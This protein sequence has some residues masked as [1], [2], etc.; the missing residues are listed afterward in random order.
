[1]SLHRI[2]RVLL[3]VRWFFLVCLRFAY[4]IALAAF[5]TAQIDINDR[6]TVKYEIWDT[7]GQENILFTFL[8]V[9]RCFHHRV[10]L[11]VILL[12]SFNFYTIS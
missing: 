11:L 2:R 8:I 6:Q 1:M 3:E 9:L 7:A 4:G 12:V 10:T 5:L